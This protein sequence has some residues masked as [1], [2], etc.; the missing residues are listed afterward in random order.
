V[1]SSEVSIFSGFAGSQAV[2]GEKQL[3]RIEG[4]RLVQLRGKIAA[5]FAYQMQTS[6]VS[7][8]VTPDSVAAAS[9]GVESIFPKVSFHMPAFESY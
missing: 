3:Y 2:P 4:A 7:L 9:G 5:Y 6:L 1:V 8:M